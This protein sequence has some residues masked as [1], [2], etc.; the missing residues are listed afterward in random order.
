MSPP[1]SLPLGAGAARP[2]GRRRIV[3][4]LAGLVAT[5][6]FVVLGL[7]QLDRA[8]LK[9]GLL[10]RHGAGGETV[11]LPPLADAQALEALR[12]RATGVW[13]AER[14]VWID[15][16]THAGR[17]GVHLLTPLRLADGTLLFVNRGWAPMPADRAQLPRPALAEGVVTLAGLAAQP[18]SGGFSLG[19]GESSPDLWP[20]IEAAR[21][22][23]RAAGAPFYPQVLELETD[24]G[25]GLVRSW[26]PPALGPD[27]HRAYAAQW[28]SF[29]AIAAVLTLYWGLRSA[30][31]DES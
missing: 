30:R 17:A 21:L 8:A 28:F 24:L 26:A 29:A 31:R 27:R 15:N 4:L 23:A 11:S 6:A 7:W 22:A 1:S 2:L 25:D 19:N 18:R 16:R 5:V 3:A 14:T 10:L 9:A 13:L 12:A 20:R